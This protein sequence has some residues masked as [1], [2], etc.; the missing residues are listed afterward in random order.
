MKKNE[1]PTLRKRTNGVK[2][3]ERTALRKKRLPLKKQAPSHKDMEGALLDD[4]N[5]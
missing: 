2:K 3:R 4:R 5:H 1:R